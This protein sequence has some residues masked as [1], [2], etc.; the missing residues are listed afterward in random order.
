MQHTTGSCKLFFGLYDIAFP[1]QKLKIKSKTLNST[2][3]I[4]SLPKEHNN[5]IESF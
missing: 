5:Y 3:M 2:W 4:K 1:E